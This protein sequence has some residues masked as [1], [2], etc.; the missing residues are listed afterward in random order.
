MTAELQILVAHND[1]AEVS[2]P[3]HLVEDP[4]LQPYLHEGIARN[5]LR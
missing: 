4:K 5:M 1:V 3:H 2:G